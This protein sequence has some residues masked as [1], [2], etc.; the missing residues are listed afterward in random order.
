MK[1][2]YM[3]FTFPLN[4]GMKS[5]FATSCFFESCLH[6]E[7]IFNHRFRSRSGVVFYGTTYLKC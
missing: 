1:P 2:C 4:P 6:F 3:H 5:L 7:S